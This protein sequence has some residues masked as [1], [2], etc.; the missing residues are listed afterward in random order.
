VLLDEIDKADPDTPNDLLVPLGSGTFHVTDLAQDI[1]RQRS[2]RPLVLVTT[3]NER[4]LSKAFMRRCVV[5]HLPEPDKEW[6]VAVAVAHY[7]P[8]ERTLYLQVAD[9]VLEVRMQAEA[10]AERPPSTAEF[11]DALQ[12][13][14][15][16]GVRPGTGA[17]NQVA[18]AT[19]A[20]WLPGQ[21]PP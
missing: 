11:L 21:T 6:L 20:K 4:E 7:G 18:L 14:R 17:W 3:N 13:C 1:S 10:A 5:L 8:G 2:L 9:Y 15:E 12:A 16:L 19:L